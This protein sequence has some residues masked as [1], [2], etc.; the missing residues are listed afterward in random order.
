VGKEE[1]YS[2]RKKYGC[3]NVEKK[4]QFLFFVAVLALCWLAYALLRTQRRV[5]TELREIRKKCVGGSSSLDT[6]HATIDDAIQSS[7][8]KIR[9]GLQKLMAYTT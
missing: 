5:E 4:M 8:I 2:S 9:E 6:S 7:S 3:I 1:W